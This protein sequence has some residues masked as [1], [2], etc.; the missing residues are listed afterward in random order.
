[1]KSLGTSIAGINIF[2]DGYTIQY[3]GGDK[4]FYKKNNYEFTS[5]IRFMC[6]HYEDEG[7]P[8]LLDEQILKQMNETNLA[9]LNPCHMVFEW[10]SKYA[11]R[12]CLVSEVT[13]ISGSC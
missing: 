2:N 4:C 1:M 6:D 11:C 12:H 8:L 9:E 5:E 7:W 10:R 13:E 3:R